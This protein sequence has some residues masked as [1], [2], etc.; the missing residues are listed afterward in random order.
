MLYWGDNELGSISRVRRDGTHRETI[1]EAINLAG[2]KQQDWLGGIA[3][4]WIAGNIYWSD[5]KRNVIEVARLDGSH[6]Y[7][8]VS[9][10]EKPSVL[11]VDPLQG[12]LFYV[13]QQHIGRVGLDGSQPFILVNQ[14][15]LNWVVSS[16]IVDMD[17]TKV[18]WGETYPDAIMR[19]DY[20]GNL[21]ELLLNGT[22]NKPA[23]LAKLGDYLY[24]AENKYNE[25]AI[26]VAPLA[27]L[28]QSQL[29]LET[30]QDAIRDLKIY[31][32]RVQHG[33][34]PCAQNNGGC[35]QLCLYNGTSVVCACAHSNLA[36][37]GVTC[38]PYENFLLFSYR[39]NIESIH[40]TDHTN[41]NW[42]I[43][44]ISNVTLMRNVIAIS[45]NY[46]EQLVYYSD[47]LLNT[48]NQVH[49][50]GSGHRVLLTQQKRVEGLAYD[51]V[52][53]QLFWTSNNDAAIRSLEL[54]HLQEQGEE[55]L[56]HVR[57]VLK[58]QHEDKPRGIAVEAC[59]GMIYWTNWNERMP[60][61][62]RAYLTGYGVESIIHTDIKMP[63]ALTFDLEAQKFYWADARLDKIE[64]V[65]YDG[66]NRVV[67][68]HTTPKHAFAMAVYGDLLFWTDWVLHAVVRANKYTGTDVVFLREH[69]AR[70]MGIIAVQNTRIN[71][72]ANQ[73]KILNGLCED[74]CILNK[75]GKAT[76]H[77]TQGILANDQRRCIRPVNTNCGK[78][79]FNCHSG[80]CIPLE[81][82]CDNVTHCLD[83]SDENPIFCVLRK[84]PE[85]HFMCQNHRCIAKDQTCDGQQQC[86][87]GSD[88]APPLCKCPPDHFRCGSGEC[89]PGKYLC[90][91]MR[92]CRDFS[93]EKQCQQRT[94]EQGDTLFEHCANST[95]CI[96]PRW[97]CDGDPDCPDGT[98]EL[99]CANITSPTC[100]PNQFRCANER[101]IAAAWRCDGDDDCSDG[102]GEHGSD[103]LNCRPSC[104]V[105]Q[106]SCDNGCIPSSWQCDG[107]TDCAD[108][109]DE[110]PHCPNRSCRAHLFQC[111]SSGRCIPQ[112]WVC[113]GEQDCPAN[114]DQGAEDEG[115][116]CGGI[117][118]VPDCQ[119]PAFLCS[120][121]E[122]AVMRSDPS[123]NPFF[124][125]QFHR[126]LH[127]FAL[128]VRWR[129]G[130]SGR[131]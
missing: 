26:K 103:E 37:D 1:L 28:S 81:L 49:F 121:G 91:N 122:C 97:R 2:Y 59:L 117:A 19:V 84:C 106:F 65:D 60:S 83:G 5:T 89:I 29:I 87:D 9:D 21:R 75:E 120:S 34:N 6:R 25:G 71:C 85:T 72:D 96:M 32:K 68:A 41:K 8:V 73:C 3:I 64:R 31:S 124:L 30:E 23:A 51:M 104:Q 105:N 45:Y 42:P 119:P 130:L 70:P 80:E 17:A 12:L 18:Y 36:A 76:C 7:V 98:D 111:K 118:H 57:N 126:S 50:N 33:T 15:R 112:K 22:I 16:L 54:L 55:N 27:N 69:V 86:G 95:I 88:E 116:Q 61:I 52:N 44:L 4:D 99:D 127:R 48:I 102:V 114:G 79:Q 39:S 67:L 56:Q 77:C 94:C 24:W 100:A 115:P 13:S 123:I 14:T 20:D 107:K 92:D 11:A 128:R 46:E 109:M 38:E 43:Q 63:N 90:D 66:T 110:G 131:R 108:G 125:Y 40:M 129:R 78:S 113:D 53:E 58:L 10:V 47:V 35:E 62:Q 93:D 101:C 74:V 82:T